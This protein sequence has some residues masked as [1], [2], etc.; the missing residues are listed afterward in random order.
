[1][2]PTLVRLLVHECVYVCLFGQTMCSKFYLCKKKKKTGCNIHN[3]F[4]MTANCED[5]ETVCGMT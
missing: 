3:N 5:L 4:K 1:M 2:S